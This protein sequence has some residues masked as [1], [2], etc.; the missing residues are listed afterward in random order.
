[1][2]EPKIVLVSACLLGINCRYDGGN[3]RDHKTLQW[4]KDKLPIP[5]CPELFSGLGF[6][7][8]SAEIEKGDGFT[9]LA[10]KTR[11]VLKN[12]KEV[13]REFIQASK[14]ALKIANF[15]SVDLALLK[16]RSP[17]CGVNYIYNQGKPVRGV[18]IFTALLLK[19]GIK[20]ISEQEIE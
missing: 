2:S 4:L 15:Y 11:V 12:G 10:G 17:T 6:P 8:P 14:E 13:T 16:E 20:V 5:L 19:Q 18:G 1:M 3:K 9:L 7:R